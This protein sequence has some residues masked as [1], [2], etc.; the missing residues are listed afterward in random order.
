[1][2]TNSENTDRRTRTIDVVDEADRE[3]LMLLGS[4]GIRVV[5]M[6][7]GLFEAA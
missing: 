4:V 1:M 6:V 2:I 7:T 5:E 3:L